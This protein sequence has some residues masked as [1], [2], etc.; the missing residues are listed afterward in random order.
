MK[1]ESNKSI[2]RDVIDFLHKNIIVVIVC[3]VI[4]SGSI[5]SLFLFFDKDDSKLDENNEKFKSVNELNF[6][7]AKPENWNILTSNESDVYKLWPLLYC[8]LFKFDKNLD[9][10]G[11]L[12]K[13]YSTDVENGTVTL[14]LDDKSKFSDG[15]SIVAKD[16]AETV[17]A[18]ISIGDNSPF[19]SYAAKIDHVKQISDFQI[20]ITFKSPSDASLTNLVFPIVSNSNFSR[21]NN[22]I[23]QVTSGK[24]KILTSDEK[25]VHLT[26]NEGYTGNR[27]EN[28]ITITYINQKS[29]ISG[30]ISI[31]AVT[32]TF[33][34][35]LNAETKAEDL[36][37][38]F[39]PI[40]SNKMEY[41]GFNF[42]NKFL[43]EK[44]LRRA[45]VNSIE[46]NSLVEDYFSGAGVTNT[47]VYYPGFLSSEKL[48]NSNSKYSPSE[49]VVSLKKNKYKK[50][51][52]EKLIDPQ[53]EDIKFSILINESSA[54]RNY[55]AED[56][57][58]FLDKLNIEVNIEKVPD[59]EYFSRINSGE[60]DIY[61]GGLE[62]DPRFDLRKLFDKS[63][64]IGYPNEDA[65]NLV[66]KMEMCLSTSERKKV[67]RKLSNILQEDVPYYCIGY[68]QY[69]FISGGRWKN[70]PQSTF[71]DPYYNCDEW[72]WEK[73]DSMK[74]KSNLKSE[75]DEA[76]KN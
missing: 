7:A 41:L 74:D 30:L 69:G 49:A 4:L 54:I 28:S 19:Y 72:K 47:S 2:L 68:Y 38:N 40:V 42:R 76:K 51:D 10:K 32:G 35:S 56:I 6:Y 64:P 27:V 70:K 22:D 16:V 5:A 23:N 25:K 73:S 55:M 15:S 59:S 26:P 62:I 61:I 37:L 53:G 13:D 58:K 71:F 48:S 39:K 75:E 52:S 34:K 9:V 44:V 11:D 66:N 36:K 1:I 14:T 45:I 46:F 60:F 33:D 3:F 57:K 8:S 63:G 12:V 67:Y 29:D 17:S 65:I 18:I 43:K 24:Y 50:S 20:L 21:S 31:G